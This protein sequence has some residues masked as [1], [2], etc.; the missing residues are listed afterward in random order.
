MTNTTPIKLILEDGTE[1]TGKSF[2]YEGPVSG[3]VVFNTAMTGYPESLTD[4]SYKGQ[5][6]TLTYPLIGNYG[7][8][9]DEK[10]NNLLKFFESDTLHISA[11][12][13]SDYSFEYSHWNAKKSLADWLKEHKIPGIYGVDTRA[14]TKRLRE[15]GTMLGKIVFN[16]KDIEWYDPNQDHLVAQVSTPKKEVY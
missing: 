12:V 13:I 2:G 3:E 9:N 15:K 7:V 10:E 1:I 14:L 5:I 8:P 6:L 4:P 11:L 16:K